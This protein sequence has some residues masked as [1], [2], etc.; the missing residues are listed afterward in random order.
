MS[1]GSQPLRV[2]LA[3]L[4]ILL[5][6]APACLGAS[7]RKHPVR[8]AKPD[9]P[10]LKL[11][12]DPSVGFPP[13]TAVLTGQMTGVEVNDPNFCHAAVTWT[14]V[15][16]GQTEDSPFRVREDPVCLHPSEESHVATSYTK[17][18]V[19]YNPGSYLFRLVIEGKDRTKV[20][21]GYAKVEVLRP[22]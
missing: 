10:R 17:T 22:Q 9:R 15:D 19:L 4:G 14:R 20:Q 11:V 21:S 2:K 5:F 18:F 8:D 16:P 12:V 1:L 3:A 6:V 13:V 7:S